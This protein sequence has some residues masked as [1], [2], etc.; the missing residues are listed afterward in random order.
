MRCVVHDYSGN[1]FQVH[2]SRHLA[3]R[4]HNVSHLYFADN[5]VPKGIFEP[6]SDDSSSLRFIGITLG[7]SPNHAAGTG[8]IGL[9]RRF[10]DVAYG[11]ETA[12]I[13]QGLKADGVLSGNTPTE[14][15]KTILKSCKRGDTRFVYWVQ[16]VYSMA[17]SILLIKRLGVAGMAI[18]WYYKRLDRHQFRDS[19]AIVVIGEDFVPISPVM[20]WQCREGVGHQEL[21]CDRRYRG[22]NQGQPVVPLARPTA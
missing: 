5:P 21:G 17:V 14:A 3:Q 19:D 1:P 12:R 20:G 18:G 22:G 11:R 2:L 8:Q 9:A 15:Q 7:G 6:R 4:G 13:I 16:D 10:A